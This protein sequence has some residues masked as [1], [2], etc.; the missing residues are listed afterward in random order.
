MLR[1]LLNLLAALSLLLCVTCVGFWARSLLAADLHVGLA[2]GRLILLFSEPRLTRYWQGLHGDV[3]NS[4]VSAPEL[5]QAV[6]SGRYIA[7]PSLTAFNPATGSVVPANVAPRVSVLA[8]FVVATEPFGGPS[9]YR[10][11]AIPLLYPAGLFALLPSVMLAS[12]LRRRRR[13][14][15]GRCPQCG[16]DLRATPGRC[17]ECGTPAKAPA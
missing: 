4:R 10:L 7:E 8:G 1:R 6:R 3:A 12:A 11:I 13:Q 5:W 14:Q 16:Y 15:T 9:P 2:D 17:P